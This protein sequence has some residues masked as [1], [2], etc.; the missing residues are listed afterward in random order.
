MSKGRDQG[1]ERAKTNAKTNAEAN[2]N[3]SKDVSD[4]AS[5]E[6]IV[7]RCLRVGVL[8]SAAVILTGLI[9][10]LTTGNSGYPEHVYPTNL[11]DIFSGLGAFKPYAVIMTGLFLLILTPVLRVGISV[12]VF[13]RSRDYLYVG[14]T[15]VVFLILVVGFM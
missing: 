14:I 4:T 6:L 3:T 10:F 7:S 5:A 1:A 15:I 13:W 2:A 9:L 8:I 12:L 11:A